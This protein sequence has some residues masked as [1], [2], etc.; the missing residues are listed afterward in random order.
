[1]TDFAPPLK[2]LLLEHCGWSPRYEI[3]PVV[4]RNTDSSWPCMNCTSHSIYSCGGG[5]F[6]GLAGLEWGARAGYLLHSSSQSDNLLLDGELSSL[7]LCHLKFLQLQNPGLQLVYLQTFALESPWDVI[8]HLFTDNKV[9]QWENCSHVS[10]LS[11]VTI[12]CYLLFDVWNHCFMFFLIV[13]DFWEGSMN[14]I[15]ITPSWLKAAVIA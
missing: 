12:L 11:G 10:P 4:G 7:I 5:S 9:G 2:W 1:M 13:L 8:W 14:L 15:S 6:L 3:L